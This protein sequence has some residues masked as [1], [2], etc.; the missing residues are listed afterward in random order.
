MEKEKRNN[1]ARTQGDRKK[2]GASFL[3]PNSHGL[4]DDSARV[5]PTGPVR[6]PWRVLGD[7]RTDW[8]IIWK[9]LRDGKGHC[10]YKDVL[11]NK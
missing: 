4:L 5:P 7:Y 8:L 9:S 3:F 2:M 6:R 10:Y 1:R 11:T